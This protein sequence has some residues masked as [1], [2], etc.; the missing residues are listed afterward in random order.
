MQ[1]PEG[2]RQLDG[3]GFEL[4]CLLQKCLYGLKQSGRNWNKTLTTI[5]VEF[6]FE[7]SETDPCF[8][9]FKDKHSHKLIALLMIYVDDM[10]GAMA[11]GTFERKFVDYMKTKVELTE[12]GEVS[13]IIGANLSCKGGKIYLNQSHYISTA[14]WQ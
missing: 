10:I 9:I 1:Q 3:D 6:G 7:R 5:L 4:I 2:Y 11:P 8:F 12:I 14:N 13:T